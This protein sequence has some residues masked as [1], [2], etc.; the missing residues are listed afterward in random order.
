MLTL[1]CN[2]F[3]KGKQDFLGQLCLSKVWHPYSCVHIRPFSFFNL[4]RISINAHS[5][6]SMFLSKET[7]SHVTMDLT[8]EHTRF[9]QLNEIAVTDERS[10]S[11]LHRHFEENKLNLTYLCKHSFVY[12]T[13][14]IN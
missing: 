5:F 11:L 13:T 7:S 1:I 3:T 6:S 12:A 8:G 4:C 2:A 10:S 14:P 9:D